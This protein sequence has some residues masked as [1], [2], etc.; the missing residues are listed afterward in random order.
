MKKYS[1][2]PGCSL[3]GLGRAY[4]ES[5]LAVCKALNIELKELE[6]WNCCGATAYMAIDEHHAVA[7]ATRD[8]ALAE[9][10]STED[11]LAPCAGCYLVLNKANKYLAKYPRI[12]GTV[13]QALAEEG[14][15]YEGRIKVRHPLE[16]LLNDVGLEAIQQKIK[17]SLRGLKVAPYYG[18]QIVRPYA[19]FDDQYNP[20]S[21]DKLIEAT[22]AKVVE[23]ALK[24]KCCGGS[25]TGTLAKVGQ[26]MCFNLLHEMKRRGAQVVATAC[27][28]CQFNLEVYQREIAARHKEDVRLPILY[29]TQLIG[30]ALGLPKKALGLQRQIV[31]ADRIPAE[32]RAENPI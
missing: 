16:V 6:D 28:L 20:T 9:T 8:L 3:K 12:G 29:F 32:C 21:M 31:A 26:E 10:N 19:V 2:F 4:E 11:L 1:Y 24:T 14:L 15:K 22:G 17:S 30:L 13:R 7:L 18:C 25:L 23:F 27:P 5:F